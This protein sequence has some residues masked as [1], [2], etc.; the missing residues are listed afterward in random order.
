MNELNNNV[1]FFMISNLG[2]GGSD[3]YREISYL[4]LNENTNLLFNYFY[5]NQ[6]KYSDSP[7]FARTWLNRLDEFTDFKS[8]IKFTRTSMIEKGYISSEH[9][10]ADYDNTE[11]AYLLDSGAAN[12]VNNIFKNLDYETQKNKFLEQYKQVLNDYYDFGDRFKFDIIIGLDL[13]GKYTFKGAE[14]TNENIQNNNQLI[15]ND[16][17]EVFVFLIEETIQYLKSKPNYHPK[18]YFPLMGRT[19]EEYM[20]FASILYEKEIEYDFKFD[21]IALGGIASGKALSKEDWDIRPYEGRI[22]TLC[23]GTGISRDEVINS[24]ISSYA[25]RIA[26]K[27]FSDR[28]IHALGAGGKFNI[29]PLA[30]SNITS[31]DTQTPARRAYDGSG[32]NANDVFNHS[33]K[34]SFAKYLVGLLNED[35]NIIN[36]NFKYVKIPTLDNEIL[37]NCYCC[38]HFSFDDLKSLYSNAGNDKEDY[39]YSKQLINHHAIYQHELLCNLYNLSTKNEILLDYFNDFVNFKNLLKFVIFEFQYE[40]A[41]L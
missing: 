15:S 10:E 34:G 26:N 12:I 9:T 19:P 14:R 5:L 6:P 23:R 22:S 3:K 18:V 38:T 35:Y 30:F 39:Y 33:A 27:F 17:E 11:V 40:K 41:R 37:C 7:A 13:G 8:F 36:R 31:F 16:L 20:K 2:G 25:A 1:S 24:I 21:G 4:D 28:P 29:L 32:T